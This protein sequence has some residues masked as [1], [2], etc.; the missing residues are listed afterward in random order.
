[1]IS[2]LISALVGYLAHRKFKPISDRFPP[3]WD[4][5]SNYACGGVLIILLFSLH[6]FELRQLSPWKRAL[7]ALILDFFGVGA[8]TVY[9]WLED[10]EN[11][12]TPRSLER[13]EL[14]G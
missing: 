10:T 5:I 3:G 6:W 2:I 11:R 8:G 9:A 1:M 4:V 7:L 14:H 13:S 12:K